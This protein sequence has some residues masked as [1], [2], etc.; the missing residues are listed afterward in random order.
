MQSAHAD[1]GIKPWLVRLGGGAVLEWA[2]SSGTA[3]S[4]IRWL[5]QRGIPRKL[6]C[7]PL[8]RTAVRELPACSRSE[9][10]ATE[11]GGPPAAAAIHRMRYELGKTGGRP[12][13]KMGATKM[14]C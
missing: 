14:L 5:G 13:R 2:R 10:D 3:G 8:P 9:L 7:Q 12:R 6:Q 11:G 4:C 1:E